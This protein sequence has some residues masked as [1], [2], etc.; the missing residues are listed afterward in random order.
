LIQ[1]IAH[2]KIRKSTD[3][4]QQEGKQHVEEGALEEIKLSRVLQHLIEF[5]EDSNN[6]ADGACA[7]G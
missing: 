7:I 3:I 5:D 6:D 4:E 1:P 2:R